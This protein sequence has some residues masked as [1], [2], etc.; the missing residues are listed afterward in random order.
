MKCNKIQAILTTAIALG[1]MALCGLLVFVLFGSGLWVARRNVSARADEGVMPVQEV[2]IATLAPLPA[3][4]ETTRPTAT[5][6]PTSLPTATATLVLTPSPTPRPT[7]TPT[8]TATLV[9]PTPVPVPAT[10]T[11]PPT[12]TPE[13][14]PPAFPFIIKETGTFPTNHLNFDIFIAVVDQKNKPLGG[15]RVTGTHSNGWQVESA[16]TAGDWTENSGA[17]HYKGG[18]VKFTAP[19]SPTGLWT[20]Q[21]VDE[22]NT[23]VAPP[24]EFPFDENNPTWYFLLYERN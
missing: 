3:Q 7:D 5:A 17:M 4:T 19:N 2:S 6:S 15:F 20:M 14:P 13:P 18:N 12:D 1:I 9:P 24:V 8:P 11:P 21:L 10:V 16:L 22:A 23:P